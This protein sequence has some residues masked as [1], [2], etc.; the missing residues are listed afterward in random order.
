[1]K[2]LMMTAA[3]VCAAICANAAAI[4]WQS[5]ALYRA[6]SATGGW[7]SGSSN[8]LKNMKVD[9]VMSV[10]IVDDATYTTVSAMST[11][12]MYA[13]A[14]GQT[15][16]YTPAHNND[17]AGNFTTGITVTDSA[18][19]ADKKYN[20]IILA[21]YTDATYG[22]MYMVT[23]KSGTANN[24]GNLDFNN[25]FG[26]STPAYSGGWVAAVPEPTSGLLLLLGFAGLAL[27]RRR[28]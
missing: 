15:A 19:V 20:S 8:A 4:N 7:V 23:A 24:Q 1:M 28:A 2:K 5:A 22:D 12:D 11:A 3:V 10:F 17:G 27:R 21:E 9:A 26:G 25:I 13:W 18:G 6:A 16:T 14:Q